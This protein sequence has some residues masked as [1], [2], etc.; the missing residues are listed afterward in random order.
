MN[1]VHA[2]S[3]YFSKIHPNIIFPYMLRPSKWF[4]PFRF[5]D[6]IFYTFLI[7][8][9]HATFPTHLTLL[10]LIAP[11]IFGDA[12]KLWSSALCILLKLSTISS[13]LIPNILLSTLFSNILNLSFSLS[14]RDQ[15]SHPYK[16]IGNMT[17]IINSSWVLRIARNYNR[18]GTYYLT[19][20]MP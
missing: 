19:A 5:S 15:A 7:F 9:M 10:D 4:L 1:P 20:I 3:P 18:N 12:Y 8:P 16:T 14:M 13:L 6:Q 2:F 17:E 11:V